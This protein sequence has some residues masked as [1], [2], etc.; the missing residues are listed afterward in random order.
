MKNFKICIYIY[1]KNFKST[2]PWIFIKKDIIPWRLGRKIF[3]YWTHG[4]SKYAQRKSRKPFIPKA[5]TF[6]LP[7]YFLQRCCCCYIT[8]I[9]PKIILAN[10]LLWGSVIIT[11][12][13]KS[14]PVS[15]LRPPYQSYQYDKLNTHSIF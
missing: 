12:K 8:W 5:L 9:P 11:G 2:V 6:W 10:V 15:H 14:I 1:S 4:A 13:S 7:C 3:L